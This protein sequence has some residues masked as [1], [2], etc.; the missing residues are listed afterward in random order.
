M[1]HEK[2]I[3]T[4]LPTPPRE[5]RIFNRCKIVCKNFD[6][7]E[8]G[9]ELMKMVVRSMFETFASE[10]A[11]IWECQILSKLIELEAFIL[12]YESQNGSE[13]DY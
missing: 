10:E 12:M 6:D 13:R 7:P 3:L 2:N 4:P 8:N 11:D 1:R 5:E 9:V